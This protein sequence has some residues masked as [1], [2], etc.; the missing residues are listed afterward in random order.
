MQINRPTLLSFSNWQSGR[1]RLWLAPRRCR[2]WFKHPEANLHC[3]AARGHGLQRVQ[4][5]RRKMSQNF[6]YFPVKM[7]FCLRQI[8]RWWFQVGEPQ[9]RRLVWAAHC[10]RNQQPEVLLRA[11]RQWGKI[12]L[13]FPKTENVSQLKNSY[14]KRSVHLFASD[15]SKSNCHRKSCFQ[16]QQSCSTPAF[17]IP[18]GHEIS[19]HQGTGFWR[20]HQTGRILHRSCN[21]FLVLCN[22]KFFTSNHIDL[23]SK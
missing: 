21:S 8:L 10:R 18:D 13:S 9:S 23:A 22:T 19:E 12:S 14:S 17:S 16:I 6:H 11:R 5:V 3:R 2:L 7:F 4:H 15:K 1:S 20:Q